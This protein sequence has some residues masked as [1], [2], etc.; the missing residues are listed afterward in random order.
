VEEI[1]DGVAR[2]P[3]A[4]GRSWGRAPRPVNDTHTRNGRLTATHLL[5]HYAP[6][7]EYTVLIMHKISP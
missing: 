2:L 6:R 7:K 3:G 5:I 1:V 4:R